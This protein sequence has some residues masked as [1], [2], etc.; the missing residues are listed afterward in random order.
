M[1]MITTAALALAVTLPSIP[2]N[3]LSIRLPFFGISVHLPSGGPHYRRSA[4]RRQVRS[5][6][7]HTR[8]APAAVASNGGVSINEP[9]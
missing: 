9:K 2:A 8:S 4:P 5:A 7:A 6:P 1:K 3:A